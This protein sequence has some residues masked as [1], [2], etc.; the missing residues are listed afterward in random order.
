MAT[1]I[2]SILIP[3]LKSFN[4]LQEQAERPDYSYEKE[5]SSVSWGDEL[6]RLRVWAANI[7][8]HQTGQSSLDFRLRDASHISKQVTNLLGD[9]DQSLNDIVEEISEEA[10]AEGSEDDG[11]SAAWPDESPT[12]ELQQIHEEVVNI[13]DCLYQLSMLIR[14]PA[15]HDLL[16]GSRIGDKAEFEFYDQEHVRNL[17]PRTEEQISQRLGHAITRRRQYFGYRERHHRKLAQGI[18]RTTTGS[19]MSETIATD[20]KTHNIEFEETSSNSGMSQTSY[21]PSLVDGGRVTIPPPPKESVGGKPF[22]CPYC[23]FLIDTKTTRSWN[24]HIF[25]DIKP[26]VCTFTDCSMP[27]RLYDS[28]REWHLHETTEHLCGE[29]FVCALC[30]DTLKSAKQYERHVARHLEELALFALPRIEMDD[31]EDDDDDVFNAKGSTSDNRVTFETARSFDHSPHSSSPSVTEDEDFKGTDVRVRPRS[32]DETY[33]HSGSV[34]G[35]VDRTPVVSWVDFRGRYCEEV[36]VDDSEDEYHEEG[37]SPHQRRWS[38]TSPYH[39][40]ELEKN[41]R[42]LEELEEKEKEDIARKKFEEEEILTEA[43]KMKERKE[44]EELKKKAIEEYHAQ[45]LE[46]FEMEKNTITPGRY[47]EA[48]EEYQAQK[49]EENAKR[50]NAKKEADEEYRERAKNTFGQEGYDEKATEKILKKS[51]R[52]ND[53]EHSGKTK[54]LTRPTYIKVHQ[55]HMSPDTLDEFS[56]PWEWDEVSFPH[57]FRYLDC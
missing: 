5:V 9:L 30:R 32:P 42:R 34:E 56:L 25:K 15:Q 12:T 1:S 17:H 13:I 11:M 19:V 50:S 28:R 47:A 29:H 41:L 35:R 52:G 2:S 44:E 38:T 39:D 37:H 53:Y 43:K 22:E 36:R 24:R 51:E 10:A 27:D 20:F 46:G 21:A 18:Q 55:K 23:F 6:G 16:V 49:L 33:E 31:A 57:D 45:R 4:E 40:D 8:A 26:Y 7:G 48:V 54:N 14:K 3:C